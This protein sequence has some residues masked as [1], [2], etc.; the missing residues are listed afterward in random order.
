MERPRRSREEEVRFKAL[1]SNPQCDFYTMEMESQ[2]LFR[3]EAEI[4]SYYDAWRIICKKKKVLV[5]SD[6]SHF[7]LVQAGGK[8]LGKLSDK[9]LSLSVRNGLVLTLSELLRSSKEE[10]L[11]TNAVSVLSLI[12]I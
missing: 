4:N 8:S 10:N 12:H 3:S 9:N 11:P 2:L 6:T 7:T 1:M 5:A